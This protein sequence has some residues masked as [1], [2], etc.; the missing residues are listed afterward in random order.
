MT[1]SSGFSLVGSSM[2][3]SRTSNGGSGIGSGATGRTESGS[4]AGSG[5][6]ILLGDDNDDNDADRDRHGIRDVR[7]G[8]DWR[9]GMRADSTAGDALRVLRLGLARD[10][11]KG[12]LEGEA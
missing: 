1:S 11:S 10:L 6:L 5:V 4:G 9:K 12:W 2:I 8:W 7:R 3:D